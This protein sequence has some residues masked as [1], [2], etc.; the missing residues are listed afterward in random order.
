[1]EV[2]FK[3]YRN[4]GQNGEVSYQPYTLDI[5]PDASVL[6][7]LV[8]IR[9]ELDGSV[10]FRGSCYRGFCGDCSLRV[11]RRGVISCLVPIKKIVQNGELV[12]EPVRNVTTV[13]DLLYDTDR[14]L[15]DKYKKVHPW[16]EPRSDWPEVIDDEA[17]KRVRLAM[18]CTMCGF[19]DEGCTVIDV[20]RDFIGPA[21]LTKAWRFVYDPRD[22]A[23]AE[24]LQEIS[25]PRGLW[26]CVHCWEA[27]EHCPVGI[28]PTHR[29]MELRDRA[30]RYG[31]KSGKQ[32]PKTARH[33]DSFAASVRQTGW[34]DE[35]R[36]ALESEGL[37][38][39]LTLLPTGLRAL[40]RGKAPLRHPKRPGA[41][42]IARIFEKYEQ[43]VQA[44]QKKG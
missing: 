28:E 20:D 17:M 34:L 42:A 18:R 39:Y 11:N 36:L 15:W 43:S 13:K 1:M 23:T 3:I 24:R 12:V 35:R 40:R 38:G 9:E 21:A 10:A 2:T 4:P 8:R 7:G 30:L 26:D 5:S 6:E 29:I 44:E 27:S 14:L 33:Y 32:N 41:E 16:L 22:G 19:C 31:I 25:E 37:K